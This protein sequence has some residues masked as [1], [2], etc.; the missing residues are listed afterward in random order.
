[1]YLL[2]TLP[3]VRITCN[4]IENTCMLIQLYTCKFKVIFLA[5]KIYTKC[6]QGPQKVEKVIYNV[7]Y[8]I[9]STCRSK[10]KPG[11]F[12]IHNNMSPFFSKIKIYMYNEKK[13]QLLLVESKLTKLSMINPCLLARLT[14][15]PRLEVQVSP[16]F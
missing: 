7:L 12:K 13:C 1:M 15:R 5:D 16:P 3:D 2:V 9:L 14:K 8:S 6:I 11:F 4:F 10:P